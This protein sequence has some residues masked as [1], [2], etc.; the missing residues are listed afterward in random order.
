MVGESPAVY[1]LSAEDGE[2]S[3]EQ[4]SR[5]DAETAKETVMIDA[6]ASSQS[7]EASLAYVI[8]SDETDQGCRL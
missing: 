3:A 5:D 1:D 6:E 8:E 7:D 2:A 4:G